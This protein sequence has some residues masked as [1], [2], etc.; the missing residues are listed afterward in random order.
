MLPQSAMVQNREPRLD[1]SGP[2]RIGRREG[3]GRSVFKI[4]AN[5]AGAAVR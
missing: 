2:T 4:G 1:G 3:T 5:R